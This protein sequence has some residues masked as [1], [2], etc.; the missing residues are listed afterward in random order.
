MEPLHVQNITHGP[1]MHFILFLFKLDFANL[2]IGDT[3]E[4]S[5]SSRRQVQLQF[6]LLF[7]IE[8]INVFNGILKCDRSQS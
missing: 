6:V 7:P 2:T 4:S 5:T 3:D 1:S 8:H